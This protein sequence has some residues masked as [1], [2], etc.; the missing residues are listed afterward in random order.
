[1]P[2]NMFEKFPVILVWQPFSTVDKQS[3]QSSVRLTFDELTA[4]FPVNIVCVLVFINLHVSPVFFF[5]KRGGE[6]ERV[7]DGKL[8]KE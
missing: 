3:S 8:Y 7:A 6:D 4:I 5:F 2:V 1:M